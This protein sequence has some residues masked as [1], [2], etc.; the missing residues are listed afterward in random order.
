[1][2]LKFFRETKA[3][4]SIFLCLVLLPMVTY[5][6]MIIDASR[7]Q[8]A[9]V[10]AQSAGDLAINAAMSEY[11]QVLED[12][13]G[14][15]ANATS[16]EQIEPVIRQYFEE[17]ISGKLVNPDK[18]DVGKFAQALTDY[19][20]SGGETTDPTK[21][22][23]NFLQM[24]LPEDT[25]EKQ[26]FLF[27]PVPTSAISNPAVMKGQI[28][29][30]M[31][32][33]GPVSIGQNFMNKL[34]FLKDTKNQS[35][36]IQGKVYLTEQLADMNSTEFGA[37]HNLDS[38]APPMQTAY[39][40]I[41]DYNGDAK[42]YNEEYAEKDKIKNDMN[43][44][45]KDLNNMSKIMV[46]YENLT[47]IVAK[48]F[49]KPEEND[50]RVYSNL[51]LDS[52]TLS[53]AI[54]TFENSNLKD[55]SS[56]L[57]EAKNRLNIIVNYICDDIIQVNEN[58]GSVTGWY[59]AEYT[60]NEEGESKK[61]TDNITLVVNNFEL[62]ATYNTIGQAGTDISDQYPNDDISVDAWKNFYDTQLACYVELSN[63]K[64]KLDSMATYMIEYKAYKQYFDELYKAYDKQYQKYQEI[65]K[66][67]N[68]DGDITTDNDYIKYFKINKILSHFSK[69]N[70]GIEYIE[71]YNN[72][73][74]WAS[75]T[76]G[77]KYAAEQ[78]YKTATIEFKK[79]CVLVKKIV[80]ELEEASTN[81]ETI[82]QRAD[83]VQTTASNLKSKEISEVQDD[84]AK[85]QI[86]SD[87]DTLSKSINPEDVRNLEEIL[88]LNESKNDG[89]IEFDK[90]Y[91]TR[92]RDIQERIKKI[93]YFDVSIYNSIGNLSEYAETTKEPDDFSGFCGKIK[94]ANISKNEGE[95]PFLT[96]EKL[97]AE[98]LMNKFESTFP[99][100]HEGYE[101][102]IENDSLRRELNEK[103]IE[104]TGIP[105][106]EVFYN[107]LRNTVE[108]K[109][110]DK[111]PEDTNNT[112]H[113]NVE[114]IK[115]NSQ[116][117]DGNPTSEKAENYKPTTEEKPEPAKAKEDE[118]HAGTKD[119]FKTAVDHVKPGEKDGYGKAGSVDVHGENASSEDA[120][121]GKEQ[122]AKANE[123]LDLISKIGNGLKDDIYL[124][125]YFTEMF[126]CQ[127]DT[128][129]KEGELTLLNGY[130]TN[131]SKPKYINMK[132]AWYG[133]ETEYILWGKPDLQ[134]NRTTTETT[135][136]LLRFVINSI[137]A[138]TA[139][140]IQSMAS[141]MA[142]ALVGWSVILVPVVQ[143][144]ITL[145]VALAESALDLQMLKDGED[146]PLIKDKSTFICS[147]AGAINK[148]IEYGT[149]KGAEFVSDKVND[150]IDKLADKAKGGTAELKK[151][152][153]QITNDF[154][155]QQ[156]Q[157]ITTAISDNFTAPIVQSV[158]ISLSKLNLDEDT[159][160]Q[161]TAE[162]QISLVIEDAWTSI[163]NNI[164]KDNLYLKDDEEHFSFDGLVKKLYDSI[165]KEDRD[166][167]AKEIAKKISPETSITGEIENYINTTIIGGKD[168]AGNDVE[169]WISKIS[170][171]IKS[172]VQTT[173]NKVEA[174][175]N[176]QIENGATN[177]KEYA[178]NQISEASDKISGKATQF[179]ADH[180][181]NDIQIGA[182]SKSVASKI[183]MNYKEYCK[184]FVFIGLV[185]KQEDAMLQRAAVLMEMNVKYA[186]KGSEKTGTVTNRIPS[187][188]ENFDI[189]KA[190]T[191]FYVQADM[192][193]G[194]LFPWAVK[195]ETNGTDAE[196][197][198]DLS[199]LG[200]NS[201]N[202]RYSG[203]AGY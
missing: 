34:G 150:G 75:K 122:L 195:V 143:V 110:K 101:N 62:G 41:N 196:A 56:T 83:N 25:D 84:A 61:R 43:Q 45:Q 14:L 38:N 117:N 199:H 173:A 178:R 144:C 22:Y 81:L 54:K 10:Q 134:A 201:V 148:A 106:K 5:S 190:Y 91:L 1:M 114:E 18:G 171:D 15:F 13:Y 89:N 115:N 2:L 80:D 188:G 32:Y 73:R 59:N 169:G 124:E 49:L 170:G 35:A 194:T 153:T 60:I 151:Q 184:L 65:Y 12:M 155:D 68:P 187:S 137:Y 140:D 129:K 63:G 11:E 76:N 21:E 74:E 33:K 107:V 104:V 40:K 92:F 133:Y 6:A 8:S 44:M 16:K 31:K 24:K 128:L 50:P 182:K 46:L 102:I 125:E 17:T 131:P 159:F 138:F 108:A 58:G 109:G 189:T 29:D 67:E 82:K 64:N 79:Y 28:I 72:F 161:E 19:A 57:Q 191:M 66:A 193:M 160:N 87:V 27:E 186:V 86:T 149:K 94:T 203:M 26:A 77:Y 95:E 90:Y 52:S 116:V 121:K 71:A 97:D 176:E 36:A 98:T 99:N 141:S 145:A 55:E 158:K 163:G 166:N 174:N 100:R 120:K 123:L 197:S 179:V 42:K 48:E 192:E 157:S 4:T 185:G 139:S 78:H 167:L 135:I 9:R 183:T 70:T 53:E 175:L 88:G 180:S 20:M 85:S 202:L 69:N 51:N 142:T 136:Y 156:T 162:K 39:E 119:D 198:L 168:K 118:Y 154:I 3:Y 132:N 200:E 177:L 164:S 103:A 152:A 130:S 126:T 37:N 30:Y 113:N 147:P 127:T 112:Q 181:K 146:V 111:K 7:L 93:E 172:T 23:T 96:D 47:K 105:E 165:T